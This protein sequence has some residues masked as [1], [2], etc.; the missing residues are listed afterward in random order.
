LAQESL[1]YIKSKTA[2]KIFEMTF[3]SPALKQAIQRPVIPLALLLFCGALFFPRAAAESTKPYGLAVR[4][5]SEAYLSMPMLASGAIPPRL[6]QTGAF[7]YTPDLV[8]GKGLIPLRSRRPFLVRWRRESRAGSPY[9]LVK[10]LNLQP[11]GEWSFPP[12]TV[13]VKTFEFPVDETNPALKRRLETR[14]ARM[15]RELAVFTVSVTNG[16]P[17]IVTLTSSPRISPKTFP[18]RLPPAS[19]LRPGITRAARNV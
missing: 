4:P 18:S 19:G 3:R 13:F 9:L 2:L 17:I 6:S 11:T 5:D 12:G 7:A 16:V 15:R 14:S 8:P 1:C 10:R